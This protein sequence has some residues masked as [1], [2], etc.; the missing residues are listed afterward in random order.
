MHDGWELIAIGH[1]SDSGDLKTKTR[2]FLIQGCIVS[3]LVEISYVILEKS[4][5]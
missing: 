4:R 1:L 3:P 2:I 5:I